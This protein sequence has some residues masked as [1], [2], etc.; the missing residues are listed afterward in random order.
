M[1]RD[2]SKRNG[3]TRDLE[4]LQEIKGGNSENKILRACKAKWGAVT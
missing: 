3:G 1:D 4:E 2:G